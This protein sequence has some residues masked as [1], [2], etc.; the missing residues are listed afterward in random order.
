MKYHTEK[1]LIYGGLEKI[2]ENISVIGVTT[3]FAQKGSLTRKCTCVL[4]F[5]NLFLGAQV[6]AGQVI[7]TPVLTPVAPL[8]G[9]GLLACK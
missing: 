8:A 9:E 5:L 1:K 6:F 2:G 3:M 4:V 7:S